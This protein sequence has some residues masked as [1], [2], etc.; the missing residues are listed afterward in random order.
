[1]TYG[2]YLHKKYF[3][4]WRKYQKRLVKNWNEKH[5]IGQKVIF[6]GNKIIKTITVSRAMIQQN[7]AVVELKNIGLVCIHRL[8]HE[9]DTVTSF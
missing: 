5:S 4:W 1:M 8:P 3:P 2:K 7:T 9:R 6:N